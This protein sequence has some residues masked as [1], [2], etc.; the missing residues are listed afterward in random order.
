M[1]CNTPGHSK[2]SVS[3]L[4][5]HRRGEQTTV[6]RMTRSS[7]P[8]PASRL[9]ALPYALC[10]SSFEVRFGIHRDLGSCMRRRC[11]QTSS[12]QTCSRDC[13]R[14][15]YQPAV[16]LNNLQLLSNLTSEI[17]SSN[18][19]QTSNARPPEPRL[20]GTRRAER[21]RTTSRPIVNAHS[22]FCNNSTDCSN[23]RARAHPLR[24][25]P[26]FS[27]ATPRSRS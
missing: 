11:Q 22:L 24:M 26:T 16:M 20:R 10:F 9:E 4:L 21:S 15:G 23:D 7:N 2:G 3:H 1:R 13:R 12:F 8:V 5:H 27:S 14:P 25:L 17:V 18:G 6:A 19:G